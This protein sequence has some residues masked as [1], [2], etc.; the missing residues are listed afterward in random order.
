MKTL[1]WL[2]GALALL[3]GC[4]SA[5]NQGLLTRTSSYMKAMSFGQ[6]SGFPLEISELERRFPELK[7]IVLTAPMWIDEYEKMRKEADER[8]TPLY[9]Y[10]IPFGAN[11]TIHGPT[12]VHERGGVLSFA[13]RD[14]HPHDVSQVLDQRNVPFQQP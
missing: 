13:F 9:E 3:A 14:L 7:G 8:G 6:P 11:I 2:A 12:D 10:R 4:G 1:I 5:P